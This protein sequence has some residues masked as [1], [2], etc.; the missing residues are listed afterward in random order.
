MGGVNVK[1]GVGGD[2][3][4]GGTG[5]DEVR[6]CGGGSTNSRKRLYKIIVSIEFLK[7]LQHVANCSR[8]L[9]K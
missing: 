6:G 9:S 5:L 1:W 2:M 8:C 4:G 3:R 7:C